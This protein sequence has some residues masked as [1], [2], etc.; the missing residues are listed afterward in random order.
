M[1][2][3]Q[4]HKLLRELL[5]KWY[6]GSSTREDERDILL[7]LSSGSALPPD[8]EADSRLFL[9]FSE[10]ADESVTMPEE[11]SSRI[12]AALTEEITREAS[13]TVQTGSSRSLRNRWLYWSAAACI[14]ML[15]FGLGWRWLAPDSSIEP[16]PLE[17]QRVAVATL[18][19]VLPESN[20]K[21]SSSAEPQPSPSPFPIRRAK[22]F[23]TSS[24]TQVLSID[25]TTDPYQSPLEEEVSDLLPEENALIASNYRVVNDSREAEEIF[26]AV[27]SR[28]ERNLYL[29]SKRIAK[30]EIGHE[31]E[32][33]RL[34]S[35]E[36][37]GMLN[38]IYNSHMNNRTLEPT[39]SKSPLP[40]NPNA[41]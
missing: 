27:F 19:L 8:I 9:A 30:I 14:A 24:E 15:V 31:S 7:L 21:E 10:K 2:H 36:N 23:S 26:A 37:I 32:M 1:T 40:D 33:A 35:I 4:K 6:A 16:D 28:L 20:V 39:A 25:A 41:I 18:P 11:Y 12:E 5:A 17:Q 22:N 13:K 38:D 3:E 34:S 29:E